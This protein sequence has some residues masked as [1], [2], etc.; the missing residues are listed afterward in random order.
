LL[1]IACASHSQLFTNQIYDCALSFEHRLGAE[2]STDETSTTINFTSDHMAQVQEA[3]AHL[4]LVDKLYNTGDAYNALKTHG[5]SGINQYVWN[6]LRQAF[7]DIMRV[8]QLT[9]LVLLQPYADATTTLF[10]Y[11]CHV[12]IRHLAFAHEHYTGD[13]AA[14]KMWY[15]KCIEYDVQRPDCH[16]FLSRA[17]LQ[18]GM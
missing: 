7:F 9:V 4:T 2:L 1:N 13:R 15:N 18:D 16:L 12:Y 14:V 17:H 11:C 6:S 8:M 10:A 5:T 3:I